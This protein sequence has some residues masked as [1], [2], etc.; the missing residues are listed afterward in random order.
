MVPKEWDCVYLSLQ[1]WCYDDPW[2]Y[3][4][5]LTLRSPTKKTTSWGQLGNKSFGAE[6][7]FKNSL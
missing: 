7:V 4:S 3:K 2:N 5:A 1:N 6:D